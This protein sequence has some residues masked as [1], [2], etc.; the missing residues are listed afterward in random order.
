MVQLHWDSIWTY[1][2]IHLKESEII[3]KIMYYH[4]YDKTG[5]THVCFW[6]PEWQH[7]ATEIAGKF[8]L[9]NFHYGELVI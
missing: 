3:R 5:L 7:L 1:K 2:C 4:M 6:G 9:V 8:M